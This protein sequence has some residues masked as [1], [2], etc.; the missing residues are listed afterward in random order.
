MEDELE[1]EFEDESEEE[2]ETIIDCKNRSLADFQI[3]VK[4]GLRTF[5]ICATSSTTLDEL[6]SNIKDILG[7]MNILKELDILSLNYPSR[8]GTQDLMSM[9]GSK[10]LRDSGLPKESTL[11]ASILKRSYDEINLK[12]R[13]DVLLYLKTI[14]SELKKLPTIITKIFT[15]LNRGSISDTQIAKDIK[16]L[17]DDELTAILT[18]DSEYEAI[19]LLKDYTGNS[20]YSV[21]LKDIRQ[22]N[23]DYKLAEE[24]IEA[25]KIARDIQTAYDFGL[26][27]EEYAQQQEEYGRL[28]GEA[29]IRRRAERQ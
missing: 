7:D 11:T 6:I 27:P 24:D 15:A 22:R 12:A 23:L 4:H 9:S 19:R 10:T 20:L 18:L 17:S 8:N 28:L 5:D 14:D 13:V 2:E 21:V 1:F 3:K 25:E 29:V 26:T 16:S